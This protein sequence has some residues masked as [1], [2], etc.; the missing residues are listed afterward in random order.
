MNE[1]G[2]VLIMAGLT[3]PL[4]FSVMLIEVALPRKIFPA[5]VNVEVPHV[6][7]LVPFKTITG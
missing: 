1:K 2:D 7:P 4:P 5:T 6:V 3:V